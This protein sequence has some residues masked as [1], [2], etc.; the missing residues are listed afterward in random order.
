MANS[1][2]DLELFTKA[3]SD[4]LFDAHCTCIPEISH[5]RVFM[6]RERWCDRD[7]LWTLD[8]IHDRHTDSW[9]F[10]ASDCLSEA[11]SRNGFMPLLVSFASHRGSRE[12]CE[13]VLVTLNMH[14]ITR[15][16]S[17]VG[18]DN[19]KQIRPCLQPLSC[20]YAVNSEGPAH[21]PSRFYRM[22]SLLATWLFLVS[23]RHI[24]GFVILTVIQWG[25]DEV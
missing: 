18:K 15:E 16:P 6:S 24:Q 22:Q 8:V 11:W 7:L 10:H 20:T 17:A 2:V 23:A 19:C 25:I 14:S 21:N 4:V 9:W 13:S 1:R 3:L 12:E 5:T